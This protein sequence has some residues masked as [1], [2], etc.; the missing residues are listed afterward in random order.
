MKTILVR[1]P[2]L[3][4]RTLV[5]SKEDVTEARIEEHLRAEYSL[6]QSAF[7]LD[8]RGG[9]EMVRVRLR[10]LGGKGGFGSNLRAQGSKMSSKRRAGTRES[11]RDLAGRRLRSLNQSR[12]INEYLARK[13]ELERRRDKEIREKMLRAVEAAD[14]KPVFDDVDYLRTMRETVDTVES[15]VYEALMEG[16]EEDVSDDSDAS[17]DDESEDEA[18]GKE[19]LVAPAKAGTSTWPV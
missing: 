2:G 17:P 12:L 10:L 3:P 4:L 16:E 5:L 11:C 7:W 18:T 14:R 6:D 15:A 8:W 19:K 13:P 1:V 9:E